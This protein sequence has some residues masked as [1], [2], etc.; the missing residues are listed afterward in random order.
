MPATLDSDKIKM[1]R[2]G[3]ER[4]GPIRKGSARDKLLSLAPKSRRAKWAG[5]RSVGVQSPTVDPI[6]AGLMVGSMGAAPLV[7]GAGR[8]ALGAVGKK[9]GKVSGQLG[10]AAIKNARAAAGKKVG[11]LSRGARTKAFNYK[12]GRMDRGRAPHPFAKGSAGEAPALEQI[13]KQVLSGGVS[14][15]TVLKAQGAARSLSSGQVGAAGSR[16]VS[17]AKSAV[18][19][20]GNKLGPGA[21][22]EVTKAM[23]SAPGRF[24]TILGDA[25]E[26]GIKGATTKPGF[27]RRMAGHTPFAPK[28]TPTNM[29]ME[30]AWNAGKASAKKQGSQMFERL[31]T[32]RPGSYAEGG[33]RAAAKKATKLTAIGAGTTAAGHGALYAADNY[34]KEIRQGVKKGKEMAG[35]AAGWVGDTTVDTVGTKGQKARK[36]LREMM[37][38]SDAKRNK[39]S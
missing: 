35:D 12:Q 11:Q 39:R 38:A 34:G 31:A 15:N 23:N 33:V 8:A 29:A 19:D 3:S 7:A 37:A 9:I 16:G 32:H 30:G 36:G 6:D 4:V 2:K 14:P 20:V 24:E 1:F 5:G 21:R 13:G 25:L 27:V 18:K 17:A 26:G 10:K 22:A 28:A